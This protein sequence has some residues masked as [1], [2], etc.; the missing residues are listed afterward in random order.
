MRQVT[1][2]RGLSEA[3]AVLWSLAFLL[4]AAASACPMCKSAMENNPVGAALSWTTLVLIAAPALLMA[5]IGGWI[6]YVYWRAA[7]RP[8]AVAW[9]PLWVEEE[10][11][12]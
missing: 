9:S 1:R 5:S 8:D 2:L 7:R 4:P 10:S 6:G 12:T 11:E 3:A